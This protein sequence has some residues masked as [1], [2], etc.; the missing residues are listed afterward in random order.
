MHMSGSFDV[1]LSHNSKDKPTVRQLAHTLQA[2]GLKV[3]LDEEQ[4]VPGRPWQE[5]LEK[6]IQ[7]AHTA[8]VLVGK[9]G[10]GPWEIPEIRT[11]LSQFV[12][13]GLPVIPVLLPDASAKP[14]LPLFLHELTWVDLRGG[15]TE[16]GLNRLEWG[17]TGSKPGQLLGSDED[18]LR[19]N[20]TIQKRFP[21]LQQH[22]DLLDEKLAAL[23]REQILETRSEEKFRLQHLIAKTKDKLEEIEQQIKAF[24]AQSYS[25]VTKKKG[26]SSGAKKKIAYD[27]AAI[28]K[29]VA[30]ALG[31]QELKDLCFD[32]FPAV[33]SQFTLGQPKSQRVLDLVD[34]ASRYFQIEK[35]LVAIKK[36]NPNA[37][38]MFESQLW[39]ED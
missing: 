17:I 6:I 18:M 4:L 14:E 32:H 1:F 37:Y 38:T 36:V 8:A 19:P 23:E 7:T 12:K 20:Q 10:L 39:L 16:D 2:R 35:L 9:D 28:R 13:R 22:R 3:W 29:L 33:Y 27:I 31:D 30:D 5:A 21:I 11:C 15:L 24:Q 25:E 34:Y 26:S